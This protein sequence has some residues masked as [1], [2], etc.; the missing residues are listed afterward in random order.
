MKNKNYKL[1]LI[2]ALYLLGIFM[3]AV[4]TGIVSPARTIIQNGLSVDEKTGIWMITIYTLAYAAVIPIAGKLADKLGRK[5]VYIISVALFGTGSIICGLSSASGSFTILLIGRVIQAMGGGGIVPIATA[6]FGTT[7]PEEKR[8]MALGLVGAVYGIAN[9]IGSS[10][11]SLILKIFGNANWHW[12][13]FVNI[14][15]CIFIIIGGLLYIPNHKFEKVKKIDKIGTVILVVMTLS[16]LY[17]LRNIDFFDFYNSVRSIEVYP[18]LLAF[19]AL[20][21]IFVIAEKKAE[22]PIMNLSYFTNPRISITLLLSVIVGV[23]MMGMVFVPQ[24]SENALKIPSGTGGYFVAILGVFAGVGAPLS[25]KLIDKYGAKKVLL[26]GFFITMLGALFIVL[27]SVKVN[28]I[29]TVVTS[30]ILIGLGMGFTIGTPLNYMMLENT[31]LE[32]SNSALATLSLVRSLG[33]AIAPAIMVGFLAHAGLNVSDSIMNILPQPTSPKIVQVEEL[34]TMIAK[35][36]SN[37]DTADMLKDVQLPDFN[38][39]SSTKIDMKSGNLP[40]ELLNS[41]KTADVTNITEKTKEISTYMF[42]KNT[43]AVIAKIEN[44]VDTGIDSMNKGIDGITKGQEGLNS[45]IKGLD[46][47]IAKMNQGVAGMNTAVEKMRSALAGQDA[48]LVQMNLAYS[49]IIAMTAGAGGSSTTGI[50]A[51]IITTSVGMQVGAPTGMPTSSTTGGAP[52]AKALKAKIDELSSA[53]DQLSISLKKTIGQKQQLINN[54]ST[55]KDKKQT[56]VTALAKMSTEKESLISAL[57]KTKELKTA[58]PNA[59]EQSKR[60]YLR[61]I[62]AS[63]GKIQQ[64][65]Q[66]VLNV[67]FKQMFLTV[68]LANLLG[69]VVLLFYRSPKKV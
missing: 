65:F 1:G 30:L 28:N 20:F 57:N 46:T 45:G 51:G 37:P 64:V 15:I 14:P 54:I 66:S 50:P 40:D 62:D 69:L 42:D 21:P 27:V 13:F 26:L 55:L 61:S 58:V 23:S 4:D 47:A 33:T 36:K 68:F 39:S 25:G 24:F 43:P 59:F 41:L 18:Y 2:M 19:F 16:I 32:E 3:G 10:I 29:A 11:G 34:N 56:M 31:K 49:K 52:D 38:T 6:E 7:F 60:E 35:M 12:L 5:Y 22:D 63:S 67:G 8:G 17:G 9:I 53:K 48:A 44:G